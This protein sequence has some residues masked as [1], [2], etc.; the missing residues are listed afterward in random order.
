[1]TKK[2]FGELVIEN[3]LNGEAIQDDVI[4]YRRKMEPQI[5]SRIHE[6]ILQSKNK[7]LYT[8]RDFYV[9][10]DFVL[11]PTVW[12]YKPL[13]YSRRSC[14]TPK[15]NQCVW[16]YHHVS[17][18]LEFMWNIPQEI[19]YWHVYRNAQ[20]Y[21]SDPETRHMAQFVTLMESGEL[22]E[23][24]KKENGE[25]LDAVININKEPECLIM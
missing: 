17:G 9:T 22:L 1:M 11:V 19:L 7:P 3:Q 14:P 24:V 15:Y 25:K 10:L 21:L 16:K 2:T 4:E 5:M 20:K 18:E 8:N 13:V 12:Q 6:V 23:W